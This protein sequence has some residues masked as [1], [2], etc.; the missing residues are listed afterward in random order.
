MGVDWR[1]WHT[2][3]DHES[4]PL[5]AR[6]RTVQRLVRSVLDG[7]PAGRLRAISMCAGEGRDLL[8][9]LETHPRVGDVTGRLVELDPVLAA[10]AERRAPAGVE[11]VCGDAST[12]SAYEGAVP[13]DVV[14]VCGVFG[15]VDDED[16]RRTVATL[17]SLCARGAH[18]IWTRHRR[19]PD[20]TYD[21]RRWFGAAGFE[22]VSFET[23]G[24]WA[25]VGLHR[26]VGEPAPYVA[27]VRMFSFV[28]YDTLC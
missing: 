24:E 12:T 15:N 9:V 19:S 18:V 6:L 8:G 13:A 11:V 2:A 7:A 25:G 4:S 27:G 28:G 26:F 5:S 21:I 3:Y 22:E 23:A 16:V 1:A 14:L 20:R 17:P 10:R